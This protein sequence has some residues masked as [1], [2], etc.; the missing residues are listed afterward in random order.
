MADDCVCCCICNHSHL[1]PYEHPHVIA[2]AVA[3]W[4]VLNDFRARADIFGM[5]TTSQAW[6]DIKLLISTYEA[7]YIQ[8]IKLVNGYRAT[9]YADELD[10]TAIKEIIDEVHRLLKLIDYNWVETALACRQLIGGTVWEAYE[11]WVQNEKDALN[12]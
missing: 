11:T 5:D 2:P 8:N 9:L 4:T 7:F 1:F 6:A 3:G 10:E 12:P